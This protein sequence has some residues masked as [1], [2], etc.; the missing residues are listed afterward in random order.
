MSQSSE[1][2]YKR[3]SSN[4]N[5]QNLLNAIIGKYIKTVYCGVK[6]T[7]TTLNDRQLIRYEY[8]NDIQEC[9]MNYC[10]LTDNRNTSGS[11]DE[12]KSCLRNAEKRKSVKRTASVSFKKSRIVCGGS[13]GTGMGQQSK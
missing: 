9:L 3:K 8:F 2:I 4:I 7:N 5:R 11:R 6:S 13:D 10:Q 12:I 1:K